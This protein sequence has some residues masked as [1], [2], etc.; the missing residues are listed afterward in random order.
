MDILN[1]DNDMILIYL[2]DDSVEVE[3][4]SEAFYCYAYEIFNLF[5]KGKSLNS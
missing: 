5:F 2:Y 1:T 3:D 4:L